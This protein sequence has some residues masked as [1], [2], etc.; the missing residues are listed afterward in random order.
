MPINRNPTVRQRR[1]ARTLRDLRLAAGKTLVQSARVLVCSEAKISRIEGAHSGVRPVDLRLLLDFYGVTDPAQRA[2]LEE[3]SR[4]G[5]KR[6]WWNRYVGDINPIYA[7]YIALE[8]DASDAF[9]V[10]TMLIPGL[11]QTEGYTR[12]V[13]KV[14]R[15]DASAD[16]IDFLTKVRQERLS[17]LN[18]PSPLRIWVVVS[19]SALRHMVGGKQ[20]MREQL[21]HLARMAEETDIHLQVLPEGAAAHAALVGPFVI[22]RFPDATETDVVYVDTLL[23][24]LY[25]EDPPDVLRYDDLFRSVMGDALPFE[26]SLALIKRV[27]REMD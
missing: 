18:R 15:P 17:V 27:A 13:V 22:L 10:E 14:Q 4:D 5:R 25:I 2:Y 1:L 20:V 11:L 6:G 8:A 19:E 9:S 7:D 3:L 24:A 26:D 23:S 21:D 12:A 16:R